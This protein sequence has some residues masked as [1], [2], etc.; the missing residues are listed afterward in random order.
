MSD[1][2][3]RCALVYR[4]DGEDIESSATVTVIAKYDHAADY[5]A[6]AGAT[7]ESFYGGRDKDNIFHK[8][9]DTCKWGEET[10]PWHKPK[11][12]TCSA[13]Q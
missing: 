11:K 12:W 5:E 1:D 13:C 9:D 8:F 10:S 3:L 4:I 7:S 2:K 6:H